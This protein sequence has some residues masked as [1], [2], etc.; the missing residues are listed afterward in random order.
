MG[1]GVRAG[2]TGVAEQRCRV[3]YWIALGLLLALAGNGCRRGPEPHASA[4]PDTLN[5]VFIILDAA[6]AKHF[7]C[8]GNDRPTTPRIDAFAQTATVFDRA[9]S[10]AA[11][12]LPSV[13]SFMTGGYPPAKSLTLKL[14]ES[15]TLAATLARNGLLTAAFSEN[16]YVSEKL[17]LAVGFQ[18]FKEYVP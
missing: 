16:P 18:T 12:T 10:Q 17:G 2:S 9:Y 8:Y 5:V 6:G 14:D 7:G 3:R 15:D 1:E 13:G 11:W 4:A